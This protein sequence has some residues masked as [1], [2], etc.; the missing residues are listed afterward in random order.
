MADAPPVPETI[1]YDGSCGFCD[2][3]VHWVIEHDEAGRFR[4]APLGGKTFLAA[5]PE[6]NRAALGDSVV[7]STVDGRL[8]VRSA[9]L[10]HVLRALGGGWSFLAALGSITPTALGD[11]LYAHVARRRHLLAPSPEE[12]PV[13]DP[14]VRTRFDD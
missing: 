3:W 14:S 11:G 4:F 6:A 9:A 8:L 10:L 13:P 5:V 1:F 2:R 12:C 7:V